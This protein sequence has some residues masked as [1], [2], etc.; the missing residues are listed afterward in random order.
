MFPQPTSLGDGSGGRADSA[1]AGSVF[2]E[3]VRRGPPIQYAK[4]EDEVGFAFRTLREGRA[5]VLRNV[6]ETFRT[7]L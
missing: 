7:E 6:M 3:Y 2:V 5:P 1:T 4:T